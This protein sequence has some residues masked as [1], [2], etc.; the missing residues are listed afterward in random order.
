MR[1]AW[2]DGRKGAI[3]IPGERNLGWPMGSIPP[4]S[5]PW[6]GRS[7]SCSASWT[8]LRAHQP[9]MAHSRVAQEALG[10]RGPYPRAL[11]ATEGHRGRTLLLAGCLEVLRAPVPRSGGD[12]PFLFASPGEEAQA[13]FGAPAPRDPTRVG[14]RARDAHR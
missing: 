4:P 5:H 2:F 10:L 8:R 13:L 11:A 14:G 7:R 3:R 9:E 1:V 12:A 6:K